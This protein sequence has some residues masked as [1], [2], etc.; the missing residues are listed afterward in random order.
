ML[1]SFESLHFGSHYADGREQGVLFLRGGFESGV[2]P[3]DHQPY[4]P[5]RAV[6]NEGGDLFKVPASDFP[7]DDQLF[8][9]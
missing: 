1:I 2:F 8:F 3:V 4:F 5:R 9:A 7:F 6:A